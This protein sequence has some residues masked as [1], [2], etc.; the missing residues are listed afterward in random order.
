[1][2]VGRIGRLL[3]FLRF[4]IGHPREQRLVAQG[5]DHGGGAPDD[6]D[7]ETVPVQHARLGRRQAGEIDLDDVAGRAD[8][9]VRIEVIDERPG[10]RDQAGRAHRR[11]GGVEHAAA[12]NP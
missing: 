8:A 6:E 1:M 7:R 10:G 11:R 2:P 4:R 3:A 12:G 5:I 9:G